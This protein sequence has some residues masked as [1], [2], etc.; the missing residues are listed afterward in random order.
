MGKKAAPRKAKP[1]VTTV[2]TYHSSKTVRGKQ[3]AKTTS[4]GTIV[5]L[6]KPALL[7]KTS[8]V[9]SNKPQIKWTDKAD[10]IIRR[11][12]ANN[13]TFRNIAVM[14]TDETGIE[15]D[16][17]SVKNRCNN[18]LG[19]MSKPRGP[20]K[21]KAVDKKTE[22]LLFEEA[23]EALAKDSTKTVTS[24]T[25]SYLLAQGQYGK[26]Q[27]RRLMKAHKDGTSKMK[28]GYSNNAQAIA[29]L[30]LNRRKSEQSAKLQA[31]EKSEVEKRNV[32]AKLADDDSDDDMVV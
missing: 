10:A 20:N 17:D 19:L 31:L 25:P 11:E 22:F 8:N 2:T 23:T 12:K 9:A 24:T 16:K 14:I 32:M 7:S 27:W 30:D 21:E 6:Q 18:H 13:T 4:C 3:T 5:M 15:C 28:R 1:T 29:Q 26:K